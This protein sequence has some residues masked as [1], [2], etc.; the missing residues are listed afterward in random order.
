M[1]ARLLPG[2][3][4][5]AALRGRA[6]ELTANVAASGGAIRLAVVTAT[7]NEPAA[8]YV[9]SLSRAAGSGR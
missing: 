6:A 8:W 3:D 9:R 5:A 1:T 7:A 2:S 4:L